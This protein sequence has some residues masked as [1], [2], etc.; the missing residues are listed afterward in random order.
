MATLLVFL[1][2]IAS[3]AADQPLA[4]LF[5]HM[6]KAGGSSVGNYMRQWLLNSGCCP[7]GACRAAPYWMSSENEAGNWNCRGLGGNKSIHFREDEYHCL[8]P[9]LDP[10]YKAVPSLVNFRVVAV[11]ILRHPVDRIISQWW[12]HGGPGHRGL[13]VA[14]AARCG[15]PEV[16]RAGKGK[17]R[18]RFFGD[19]LVE[20]EVGQLV[21]PTKM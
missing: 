1:V 11:T 12:Y 2:A 19:G 4:V 16:P 8:G 6:R 10:P 3:V 20:K 17:A 9:S 5:V 18:S 15:A 14:V 13:Q 21:Q 7:N